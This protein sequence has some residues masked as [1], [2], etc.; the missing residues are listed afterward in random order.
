MILLNLVQLFAL[1]QKKQGQALIDSIITELPKKRADTDQ[2]KLLT[3]LSGL[4]YR[5]NPDEGII[6]GEQGLKIAEKIGWKKG[7][8]N[9]CNHL[10][11]NA[12]CKSDYSKAIE[13]YSR[14]LKIDEELGDEVGLSGIL[15]NIGAIY[16]TRDDYPQALNYF[17]RSAKI[18]EKLS[19]I[20]PNKPEYKSYYANDLGNIGH[21][22]SDLSNYTK[23]MEYYL[24]SI[25]MYEELSAANP[26][27]LDSKSGIA[28][29]LANMG[30]V[31]RKQENY[32]QALE[33]YF[34]SLKTNQEAGDKMSIAN[35]MG[36]IGI[37]YNC[38]KEFAKALEYNMKALK[39][40]EEAGNKSG[41]AINLGNMGIVYSDQATALK[42][43]VGLNID[44][45]LQR[46]VVLY[47]KAIENFQKSASMDEALGEKDREA[48]NEG[49]M[50]GTYLEM[51]KLFGQ[52]TD[53][54]VSGKTIRIPGITKAEAIQKAN[55]CLMKAVAI[56]KEIG[57][58]NNLE[59]YYLDLFQVRELS[60]NFKE[61]L[62]YYKL[63]ILIRD[64]LYSKEKTNELTR[65]E[66]QFE[67][68]KKAIADSVKAGEEKKV[69]SAELKQEKTTT[70]ALYGGVS[71]LLIFGVF[72]FNRYRESQRQKNIIAEEKQ[73][74]DDLLLNILPEEVAEELKAKGSAD[75]KQFDDVT[76]M[77]TDFKGFTKISEHL[78]PAELVAEI[79]TCFQAFDHIITKY[80]I[81]KIKT[82]GDSYMC[83]GGLPLTNKTHPEDVVKAA[84]EI[85]QF[86]LNYRVEKMKAGKESFEIRIGIHTGPVVAGIVGVKKFA[87]DIWGDTV[88]TASRM[89][90][91]GEAGKV[92][93]SGSTYALVKNQ[94]ICVHRGKI[95]AK[96]KGEID[97][98]FVESK[99]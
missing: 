51:A 68:D 24:K 9:A 41:V 44:L 17:L 29:N 95:A 32:P 48:K 26:D 79:H 31:Y 89:E 76:V 25:R 11:V 59:N 73:R 54:L 15:T 43:S 72:I 49:N 61:A 7:I 52:S 71:L 80:N 86:M 75:A 63:H 46:R 84:L 64:S 40:H 97:M 62:D 88:N 69:I 13:Y 77:F 57:D 2:I 92:N 6:Y 3:S 81:E 18:D 10:G 42:D 28:R 98:Y 23:A 47:F 94:F 35:D 8:A 55:A 4:F 65:K 67:Y 90:S 12:Q 27:D 37:V 85:Q 56:D 87:Y 53:H 20:L 14:T 38:Q 70:Y 50:G 5:I 83:A 36:N 78:S 96:H 45:V 39:L 99:L 91:S 93:I 74:S 33:C 66:V 19:K 1:G 60:G 30:I 22:Y 58:Q 82:I 16:L 21:V 34:Q